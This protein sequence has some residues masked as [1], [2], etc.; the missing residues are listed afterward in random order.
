M[1]PPAAARRTLPVFR[2]SPVRVGSAAGCSRVGHDRS[3]P[4]DI[5]SLKAKALEETTRVF[6]DKQ[7][8]VPDEDSEEWEEEYRRQFARVKAQLSSAP[9]AAATTAK[10]AASAGAAATAEPEWPAL[11]GAPAD[12]RWAASLRAERLKTVADPELRAWLG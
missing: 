2:S 6:L 4:M 7:G 3:F 8:Y 5:A 1:R 11:R 9:A 12:A 10:P